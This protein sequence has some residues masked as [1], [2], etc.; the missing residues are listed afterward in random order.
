MA[1]IKWQDPTKEAFDKAAETA[2]VMVF[3]FGE[4]PDEDQFLKDADVDELALANSV[5]CFRVKPVED[6]PEA[7]GTTQGTTEGT[8]S[9]VPK[10]PLLNSNLWSAYGVTE[11]DRFV[12]ADRFG[13]KVAEE[14]TGELSKHVN[15]VSSHFRSVRKDI[16]KHTEAAREALDAKQ[17]AEALKKLHEVFALGVVGYK[18]CGE[19]AS[20]YGEMMEGA[21]KQ[22]A[23]CGGDVAKL[24]SLSK[25]YAGS[26]VAGEI[27][28]ALEKATKPKG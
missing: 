17:T 7:E 4:K 25:L 22:L 18:E 24:D 10:S 1:L 19:A 8:T 14:S 5:V 9:V 16:R 6:Q 23:E 2:Q 15:D 11:A 21:R 27:D 13:N 26:D 12:V 28:A 20:L 3:Y